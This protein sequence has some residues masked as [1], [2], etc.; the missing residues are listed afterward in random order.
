MSMPLPPSQPSSG[1]RWSQVRSG[2]L[3]PAVVFGEPG[4]ALDLPSALGLGAAAAAGSAAAPGLARGGGAAASAATA[5][6]PGEAAEPATGAAAPIAR[7]VA[8][9]SIF[10][11]RPCTTLAAPG[12]PAPSGGGRASTG[13]PASTG[14]PSPP[15]SIPGAGA[16]GAGS[17][18]G[19]APGTERR[20]MSVLPTCSGTL[21]TPMLV[22]RSQMRGYTSLLLPRRRSRHTSGMSSPSSPLDATAS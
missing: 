4:P 21:R 5:A 18:R 8:A 13:T 22:T 10:S 9:G 12:G 3:R 17:R 7:G 16:G 20:Y 11:A 14:I 1:G 2:F 19:A 15:P 6:P